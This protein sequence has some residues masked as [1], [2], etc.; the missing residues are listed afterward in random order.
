MVPTIKL[1]R[2]KMTSNYAQFNLTEFGIGRNIENAGSINSR[3]HINICI[4]TSKYLLNTI[5]T[6][7]KLHRD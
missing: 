4:D 6:Y 2:W 5:W 1:P 7:L 3:V